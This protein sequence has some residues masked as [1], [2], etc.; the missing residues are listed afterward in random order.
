M[1]LSCGP[2]VGRMPGHKFEKPMGAKGARLLAATIWAPISDCAMASLAVTSMPSEFAVS[3]TAESWAASSSS[4]DITPSVKRAI[5]CPMPRLLLLRLGRLPQVRSR[6][7]GHLHPARK[8]FVIGS[9]FSFCVLLAKGPCLVCAGQMGPSVR[10]HLS[11]KL[12]RHFNRNSLLA[13]VRCRMTDND[14]K[15][16]DQ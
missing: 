6:Y 2:V 3:S 10:D 15:G 8:C 4:V 14:R 1:L 7:D 16:F 13:A 9:T 5:N 11:R 12:R